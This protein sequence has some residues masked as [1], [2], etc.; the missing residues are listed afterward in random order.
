MSLRRHFVELLCIYLFNHLLVQ[1]RIPQTFFID[2]VNCRLIWDQNCWM[3]TLLLYEG[4]SS[5]LAFWAIFLVFKPNMDFGLNPNDESITTIVAAERAKAALNHHK[6]MLRRRFQCPKCEYRT[7][8]KGNLKEHMITHTSE[9]PYLCD[10]CGKSFKTREKLIKHLDHY[11]SDEDRKARRM[12]TLKCCHCSKLYKQL[13][14]LH[15]HMR[16]VHK[17]K[18][19]KCNYCGY[20]CAYQSEMEKHTGNVHKWPPQL[21]ESADFDLLTLSA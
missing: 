8:Y 10:K 19:L 18:K 21:L 12:K 20:T 9:I 15:K 14:S 6:V 11:L 17:K 7:D 13:A 2:C 16:L 3:R 4:F 5:S 1:Q